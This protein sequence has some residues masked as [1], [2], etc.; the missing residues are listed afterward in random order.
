MDIYLGEGLSNKYIY[1][2]IQKKEA[3]SQIILPE[4]GGGENVFRTRI[5]NLFHV[6][7]KGVR[8]W[9]LSER[10]E[11]NEKEIQVA[12]SLNSFGHHLPSPTPIFLGECNQREIFLFPACLSIPS[13]V[14]YCCPRWQG[15]AHII[16]YRYGLECFNQ[17]ESKT[18]V[19]Q[20][21]PTIDVGHVR[22][23]RSIRKIT[24]RM[25]NRA[26]TNGPAYFWGCYRNSI[27]THVDKKPISPTITMQILPHSAPVTIRTCAVQTMWLE[28]END[29]HHWQSLHALCMLRWKLVWTTTTKRGGII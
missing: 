15:R 21:Y 14:I 27:R 1:G 5:S 6:Q 25:R 2:V 23:R 22:L 11:L 13:W 20:N 7:S 19:W 26:H 24:G 12:F 17:A 18:M 16:F 3:P 4:M 28:Y 10:R 8:I 9:G 29:D